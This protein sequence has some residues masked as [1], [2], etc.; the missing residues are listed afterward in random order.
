[1]K[2]DLDINS[3]DFSKNIPFLPG[4]YM[5]KDEKHNIIYIGKAKILRK[6]VLQYFLNSKDLRVKT[7]KMIQAAKFLSFI[8]TDNEVEALILESNLIKKYQ[9]KYNFMLKDDK[10][11]AWVKITNEDF[12]K[13]IRVRE[14]IE[15]GSLYY[16]PYPSGRTIIELLSNLRKLFPYRTCNLKIFEGQT[17]LKSRLCIYYHINLCN[18]PCDSLISKKEYMKNIN[19][20]KKYLSGEKLKVIKNLKTQMIKESNKQNFEKAQIIKT[21][22]D[23]I[24]YISQN[25]KVDF[26]DD[27]EI[28]K[29][30]KKIENIQAIKELFSIIGIEYKNGR[31]ECFD[32][33]N[34]Q[35]KFPVSSMV[36]LREGDMDNSHYR[37]FKIRSEDTP[38]D[39]LM[40][41]ETIKRRFSHTK[42]DKS[43]GEIPNLVIVD[44]G[45]TQLNSAIK[46]L[47]ELQLNIP[48]IGLAKK[49][50]A[51]FTPSKS[52][53]I[54]I[55]YR[56]KSHLLIRRIRDEAH[57]FAITFHKQLRSKNFIQK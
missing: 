29:K 48:I 34:I 33:S 38:N 24:E 9:P 3:A 27:E 20:I 6:R 36:V 5:F 17:V 28:F 47:N 25:I 31:I 44:G 49:K 8:I 14:R 1:M 32:I 19:I 4:C 43:F 52:E 10:K 11:Y 21:Q 18:G 2:N 56:E 54:L 41:Y 30:N 15:D 35:G 23:Q 16:G 26:G 40:M 50:E 55:N 12:P 51:I 53:P 42:T 22:I 13:I 45:R 7:K 37:K 46:A 57:R 39:P